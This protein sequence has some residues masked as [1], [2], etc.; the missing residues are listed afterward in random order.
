MKIRQVMG[1]SQQHRSDIV[2]KAVKMKRKKGEKIVRQGEKAN[3]FFIILSGECN[4]ITE[5]NPTDVPRCWLL[6]NDE[7]VQN[8]RRGI[9]CY[10][11]VR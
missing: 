4:V 11:I 6:W 2:F 7:K 10:E 5:D 9:D 8:F 3:L 1:K